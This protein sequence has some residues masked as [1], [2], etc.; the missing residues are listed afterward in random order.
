MPLPLLLLPSLPLPL[1]SLPLLL[2]LAPRNA[3]QGRQ[4]RQY[5]RLDAKLT[6]AEV[7]ALLLVALAL[8][9]VLWVRAGWAH[10]RER[11]VQEDMLQVLEDHGWVGRGAGDR[12]RLG[13]DSERERNIFM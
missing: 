12:G 10:I 5:R 2:L 1:V 13:R 6:H 3:S 4:N 11:P 8:G 9:A 7:R